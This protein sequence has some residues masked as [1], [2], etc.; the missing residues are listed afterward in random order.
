MSS[1]PD[2]HEQQIIRSWRVN[3]APWSEAIRTGSIA[4][5]KLATDS[6]IVEAVAR[7]APGRVLDVGCGEGWLARRLAGLGVEVIGIDAVPALVAQAARGAGE[8]YVQD[9]ASLANREFR[10]RPCDAAVCNFSLL[11]H[12]SV[13]SMLAALPGYLRGRGLLLIQTLH[14]LAACGELPYED[15]WRDG[16]WQ[17]FSADFK[18]PAPWYFRTLQSWMRM[19]RRCGFEL[20]DF[21][22][23]TIAG[24]SMPVS[25]LFTCQALEVRVDENR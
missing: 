18:D 4:S 12:G 24:S 15:G 13:E 25:A 6:A 23:P 14:P 19:L 9:Y 17:G 3:A 21:C 1:S 7:A 22:E 16:S 11:G 8:F 5:R 20:Q 10:C 2:S